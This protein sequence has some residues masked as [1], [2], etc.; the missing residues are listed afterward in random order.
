MSS[1]FSVDFFLQNQD[2]NYSSVNEN[3]TYCPS[4]SQ[5]S[6][7]LQ[8]ASARD[9]SLSSEHSSVDLGLSLDQGFCLLSEGQP[10]FSYGQT[11]EKKEGASVGGPLSFPSMPYSWKELSVGSGELNLEEV[12]D[13]SD[14]GIE[15]DEG[16][17]GVVRKSDGRGEMQDVQNL[18]EWK[19]LIETID[20]EQLL[21]SLGQDCGFQEKLPSEARPSRVLSSPSTP[22]VASDPSLEMSFPF[23]AAED[24]SVGQS[25]TCTS[26]CDSSS[27]ASGSTPEN[28]ILDELEGGKGGVSKWSMFDRSFEVSPSRSRKENSIDLSMSSTSSE[29]SSSEGSPLSSVCGVP[30]VSCGGHLDRRIPRV[31]TSVQMEGHPSL[32]R[33]SYQE[34]SSYL[35]GPPNVAFVKPSSSLSRAERVRRWQTK[36]KQR[37]WKSRGPMFSTR[38]AC[39]AKRQRVNGRF[40]GCS[41]QFVSINELQP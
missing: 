6:P 26:P 16:R 13:T 33:Q 20:E 25:S 31:H 4:E 23:A 28:H 14:S 30:S 5:W 11:D 2:A 21:E 24:E 3:G 19:E 41:T 10:S 29:C 17:E 39:A 40:A 37:S 36:R 15:E 35:C 8:L 32:R 9:D 18:Q 34:L 38:Q 7:L 1:E 27:S 22:L 12:G